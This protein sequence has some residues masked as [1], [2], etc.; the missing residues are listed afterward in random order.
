MY[1][2]SRLRV[3]GKTIAVNLLLGPSLYC[4]LHDRPINLEV[5]CWGQRI[6]TLFGKLA[7]REMVD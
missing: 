7:D 4:L 1:V 2:E 6:V 5:S 3:L